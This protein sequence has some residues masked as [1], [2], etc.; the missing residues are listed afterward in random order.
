M[1]R[2]H[3]GP[4]FNIPMKIPLLI[5]S[6]ALVL[7]ALARDLTIFSREKLAAWCIVPFDVKKRAP[8][9]REMKPYL[10]ALNLNG[11]V[12]DGESSGRKILTIGEGDEEKAMIA[13]VA[14]SGW[15]GPVGILNHR[16]DQDAEVILKAN[17][18]GL[19]AL[20]EKLK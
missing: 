19:G 10:I 7:P 1:L 3:A 13:A 11:M 2:V 4:C 8:A 6:L 5:V 16:P 20:V 9:E 12:K 14:D 17:R 18:D 15:K